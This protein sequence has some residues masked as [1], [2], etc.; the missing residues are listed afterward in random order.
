MYVFI[1]LKVLNLILKLINDPTCHFESVCRTI[2]GRFSKQ[3]VK[4]EVPP[5]PSPPPPQPPPSI[6]T[7][8][9][10]RPVSLTLSV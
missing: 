5:R 7:S 9:P 10:S 1:T 3:I 2:V 8:I 6:P 4:T